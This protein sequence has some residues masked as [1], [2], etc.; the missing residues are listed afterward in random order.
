MIINM[1]NF[2]NEYTRIILEHNQHAK[3]DDLK[4]IFDDIENTVEIL[5]PNPNAKDVYQTMPTNAH[6][7]YKKNHWVM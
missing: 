7:E 4:L 6:I 5:R 3:Y 2:I 1:N